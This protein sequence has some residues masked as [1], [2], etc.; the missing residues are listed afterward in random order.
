MKKILFALAVILIFASCKTS[1]QMTTTTVDFGNYN[2]NGFL[3]TTSSIG[4]PYQ[5]LGIV[6][7]DCQPGYISQPSQKANKDK[8]DGIYG[9]SPVK[10][11]GQYGDCNRADLV[12]ALYQQ[13]LQLKANALIDVKFSD[14]AVKIGSAYQMYHTATGMAVKTK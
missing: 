11:S 10:L 9:S 3:I 5:S 2:N 13:A 8:G 4:V 14:Y 7:A 1:Y 12:D 6:S